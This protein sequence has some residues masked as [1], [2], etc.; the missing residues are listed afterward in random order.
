MRSLIFAAVV[1]G[2]TSHAHAHAHALLQ[3]ASPGVGGT[4][5]TAPSQVEIRFSEGLEPRFSSIEVQDSSGK[6]VDKGDVHA[7]PGDDTRLAVSL[8]PVAPGT[9]KVTW[10]ATSVDT[11]K[12][13][14]SFAFTV[15][16]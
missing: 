9:Y 1:L 6:R 11:H 13:E 8:N 14:G 16:P 10:H 7:A 15:A 4:V 12:T 3:S 2:A 5:R